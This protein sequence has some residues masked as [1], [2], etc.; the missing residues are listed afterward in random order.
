[1]G[2]VNF[3]QNG[4]REMMLARPDQL[5]Q[6]IIYKH[7]NQNIPMYSQLT[8]DMDECAVF[9]RDGRLG[10][11]GGPQTAIFPPGRHTLQTQNLPILNQFV[12]GF[13]G[14]NVFIA[15]IFFV[16]TTPVRGVTM[17]GTVGD[18]ED[19]KT[20]IQVPLRIFGEF[21]VVVTDPARFII[22]YAGQAAQGDNESVLK[23]V[24]D[25][26]MMS[27][28]SVMNELCEADTKGLTSVMNNREKLAQAFIARAPS[29]NDIGVRI[30]EVT[31]IEPNV[32]DEY[33]E[34][35]REAQRE[36]AEARREVRKKQIMVEGAAA[37]A[38]AKQ[39]ELDQKYNQDAKYV[40]NLAGSYQGYAA[41]QAMIGAGQGMQAHGVGDGIAGAGMQM[42]MGVNMA[43]AMQGGMHPAPAPAPA[44]APNFSAGGVMVTC[45]QCQTKQPGGKFC[46]ECGT[47]LAQPKK[48]CI[49]CGTELGP[50]AKFCANCG[51]SA[52]AAPAAGGGAGPA[53]AQR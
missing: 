8:V 42:A 52:N 26:F 22:D 4:V 24:R 36:L 53:S 33:M 12:Q 45:M 49:G 50:A 14:G 19:P 30:L 32:P 13:T 23:I 20:N 38:A 47:P 29:L 21:S 41:G 44:A 28:S 18:F 40:Q 2:V 48:F 46:A 37:D 25:K 6:L 15:E 10:G 7:P 3:L 5:K 34:E 1:M 9:F 43:N 31:R 17:G 27:V 51:T 11:P 16:K 39:F 35:L